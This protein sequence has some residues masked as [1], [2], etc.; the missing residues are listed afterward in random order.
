MLNKA[1]Y[2]LSWNS[3]LV[4]LEVPIP[5]TGIKQEE[6]RYKLP[7]PIDKSTLTVPVEWVLV[8]ETVF[9]LFFQFFSVSPP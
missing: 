8:A 7:C 5:Q 1:A 2:T 4:F 3:P 6:Y 9:A